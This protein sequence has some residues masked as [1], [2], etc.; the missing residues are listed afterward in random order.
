ME[1]MIRVYPQADRVLQQA[2]AE[3]TSKKYTRW[4]LFS[5]CLHN[6]ERECL[7]CI[8][9]FLIVRAP[10]ATVD[11]YVHDA[12]WVRTGTGNPLGDTVLRD[13]EKHVHKRLGW[14]VALD[15]TYY[16]S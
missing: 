13:C 16:G 4:S 14:S 6:V 5:W 9:A 10:K 12:V 11:A 8:E 1:A 15:E 3:N 2:L 7:Q